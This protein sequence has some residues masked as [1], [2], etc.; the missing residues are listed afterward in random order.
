MICR[1]HIYNVE[2]KYTLLVYGLKPLQFRLWNI[3]ALSFGQ[4]QFVLGANYI[5]GSV[6]IYSRN[7]LFQ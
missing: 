3:Q 6:T 7:Q 1:K 2:F 4:K 5:K